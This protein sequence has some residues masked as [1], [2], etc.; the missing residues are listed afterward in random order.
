MGKDMKEKEYDMI[1]PMIKKTWFDMEDEHP[2]IRVSREGGRQMR[3]SQPTTKTY[4]FKEIEH[5]F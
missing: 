3:S 1:L 5:E 4:H 2:H